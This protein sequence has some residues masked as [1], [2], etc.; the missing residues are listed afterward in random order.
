[1]IQDRQ[2]KKLHRLLSSGR[3]L[4][5]SALRTG[6][7][8]RTARKYRSMDQLPS[9]TRTA[10][11]YRTRQDPLESIWPSIEEQLL[12][13]PGLQAKTLLEWLCREHPGVYDQSHLRTLQRRIKQWRGSAGPAKEVFFSQVHHAGD[14]SASDFSDM[15]GLDVTIAG[16]HHAH[17]VYHFVLTYSNWEAITVCYSESFESLSEGLQNALHRLGG[18]PLRHRTDR[19]SA[20]V[21]NQCDRREFT[22]RYQALMEHYRVTIEKTQPSSPNENGDVE[23]SHRGFKTAVDQALMLRGSRE[24]P[25]I[26]SYE[27][28]LQSLVAS[29]NMSRSKRVSED[30]GQL[31][32]LP[33]SRLESVRKERVR[34]RSGSLI[35]VGRN[36]Y[37]VHSRLIGEEVEAR[38]YMDHIEIWYAQKCVDRFSRLRG[39]DK[40]LIN[41][42]HIIDWLVRKPG[43]FENYRYQDDLFPTTNFRMAYDA[44]RE[45]H[46]ARRSA[47][48]YL[49]ILHLAARES[50]SQVDNVLRGLLAGPEPLSSAQVHQ[51][52]QSD[53]SQLPSVT[54][55]DIE[56][57]NLAS[58]DSLL[59]ETDSWYSDTGADEAVDTLDESDEQRHA[60]GCR[61]QV[62]DC[63]DVFSTHAK[64]G[65]YEDQGYEGAVDRP[66]TGAPVAGIS[67]ELR[68]CSQA[69]RTA[70]PK[71][72]A[73][74]AGVGDAGMPDTPDESHRVGTPQEPPPTGED[75]GEF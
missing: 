59:D 12:E 22:G 10:R 70:E 31:R 42:R 63:Q 26:Q 6:M 65:S 68:A 56:P 45:R 71:L 66:A 4:V 8:E 57:V 61:D 19:L 21:N 46:D 60:L 54:D 9:E 67:G 41:Y 44:L 50:E 69:G 73:I 37:W 64:E 33:M 58:F 48:E 11:N 72:R 39:R 32:G 20:A 38:I 35:Q 15:S 53:C 13:S 2:V 43:A 17:M 47:K 16:Q 34:V 18:V 51:L 49:A 74:P 28:F 14:L 75:A 29:R 40:Q 24:F 25:N 36:T 7:S 23:S 27:E 55:V 5:E 3:T 52:V 1:M 30:V 62:V